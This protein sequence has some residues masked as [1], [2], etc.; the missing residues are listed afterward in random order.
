MKKI[1][2]YDYKERAYGLDCLGVDIL[3]SDAKILSCIVP[4]LGR[5]EIHRHF[6]SEIFIFVEGQGCVEL[7]TESV[8][9][10][11]GDVIW[12]DDFLAHSIF[13]ENEDHPLRFVSIYWPPENEGEGIVEQGNA[14]P[15]LI[16]STSPTPNGDLHLG[17]L[18]G[19]Y[20]A[21]DMLRRACIAAGRPAWHIS[22]RDDHQTYVSTKA[23]RDQSPPEVVADRYA[24]LI[25]RTW[26]RSAIEMDGFTV[27][28][29][30]GRYAAFVRAGVQRLYDLG[31]IYERADPAPFDSQGRY[32]HE[33]LIS[34]NCPHCGSASDGNACEAC[35][36]PNQCVDL[37]D[38]V[39]K[40][41]LERP[42]YEPGRRLYFKLSQ[43]QNELTNYVKKASMP[44]S[45]FDLC[46]SML[47]SQLPDICV[48]H[49]NEWGIKHNIPG[50]E[51]QVIYVW[52]EMAFGY[53]WSATGVKVDSE[54]DLLEAARQVYAGR[55]HVIHC[56][57][58]DNAYYH[59]LLF[60]A[61]YIALG[62]VP[63]QKHI[64]NEL[65]DLDGS[66][67]STSRGHLIWARDLLDEVSSD[68]VRY[69]LS[70]TRPEGTRSDF[71]LQMCLDEI[72]E[73]FA[74]QLH[75][76]L[77]ITREGLHINDNL[78]TE[79]GAWLSDHIVYYGALSNASR[80]L[81]AAMAL[82]T[83]SSREIAI[84]MRE[85]IQDGVRF[86]AAQKRIIVNR[87]GLRSNYYRTAMA[88]NLAALRIVTRA[89]RI[90]MPSLGMK[91]S[92]FLGVA[93]ETSV[94]AGLFLPVGHKLAPGEEIPLPFASAPRTLDALKRIGLSAEDKGKRTSLETAAV[95]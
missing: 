61:M 86:S 85:V 11:A 35:G 82:D 93:E 8:P 65:L 33:A 90:I 9:V 26:E 94:E 60:P 73:V 77:S 7:G 76:W 38:P 14:W 34:G 1:N 74:R 20:L 27:P 3:G 72:N 40:G 44:A 31:Y 87:R 68:Y 88:L 50:F 55:N 58:F 29:R 78:A 45:V 22:G 80:R 18:S 46:A 24:A 83:F 19:P 13:N 47:E 62:I 66:K 2:I 91:L 48:S 43:F 42:T 64:V 32:L 37:V 15:A 16:F 28:D 17:H 71:S 10:A 81:H 41:R 79:P 92:M 30:N 53:L 59:A 54:D 25:F 49:A 39:V 75:N 52:F 70:V 84:L 89:A 69:A 57:G 56:Y 5:S 67:F 4:P 21:A 12:V 63:P 6:E 95:A 23:V 36:R 51:E